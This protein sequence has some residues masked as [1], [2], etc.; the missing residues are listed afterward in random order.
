MKKAAYIGILSRGSTS[1]MR[2]EW[3]KKLTPGMDWDWIDTAPPMQT[4]ARMW[5][6]LAFRGQVGKAV[7][8]MNDLVTG[9]V[10]ARKFDLVW[11]DKAMFLRKPT[12]EN[13]RDRAWRL[14]HFTPD[15]A[16][17]ANQSRH[18]ART[19]D[20]YDLLVTTKSFESD[21]YRRR[22]SSDSLIVT[23]QG[24]DPLVH[25]PRNPESERQRETVFVGLAEPDREKCIATLLEHDIT[26]RLGGVGWQKFLARFAR[27]PRLTFHGEHVLGDAYPTLLSRA[28]VGLGLLSTRFPELHTTRTFEIP[29]CGAALATVATSDTTSFFK[30]DEA[31]FFKDY[32]E[33]AVRL[34]ELFSRPDTGQLGAIA[35]AGEHRVKADGRDYETI[36]RRILADERLR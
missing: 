6:T 31:L 8:A 35:A 17:H 15:T 22:L 13:V 5:R 28:L 3:L 36:L 16:F 29:A 21:E 23:T 10:S 7:D 18:F 1:R 27:H 30:T 34:K 26:V 11:I 2:A 20:L 24:Y 12:V 14:V 25:Y 33:L 9:E 4:S 32:S 19:L